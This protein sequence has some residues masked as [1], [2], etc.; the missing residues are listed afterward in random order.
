MVGVPVKSLPLLSTENIQV[1]MTNL[2]SGNYIMH[3]GNKSQI[4]TQLISIVK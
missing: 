2:D 3:I 4:H 1:D